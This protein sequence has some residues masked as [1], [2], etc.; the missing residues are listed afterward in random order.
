MSR[1]E[2]FG[3]AGEFE[4]HGRDR[5][6]ARLRP[7]EP[8]AIVGMAC[9]F[10]GA[11]D[12][13]ALWRLLEE[14][15]NAVA[16]KLPGSGSRRVD[17]LFDGAR[18][19]DPACRFC[20]WVDDIDRFDAGFFRI[21][22]VEARLLDPQQRMMLETSWQALEDAGI[23]P[24]RLQGTRTGV[25]T[26]I[27]ND[28]YRMLV[29]DSVR[30]AEAASSLYALS[31]TNLNGTSGRVSFV[32][33]LTG[34]AKAVD[35]ACA[36]SLVSVHD[37][38]A[39]LQ[40]GKADLAIA[41]GVQAILNGRVFELR[42]DSMMLSPDGQC[43]A[44]DASAN[45]YVRGEG[46]GVV[47]LKRLAE[48]EADGDRIWGVIR[49]AAVN[50]GGAS[51]GLTVPNAPALEQVMWTALADAGMSPA[52][53]DY[54]EAH[55]TGT[56][57]GDPIE[58][59][60]VAAVY[61]GAR[62]PDRPLLVGSV[63][64][65]VGHLES[66]AGIAGLIK[67]VLVVERGVIP[68]HLHFRNPNPSLDWEGLPLRVTSSA[69]ELPRRDGRPRVAGVN[70]FGISGTN[71]H[72]VV[73]EY[74]AP[75]RPSY[76]P[77]RVT[78]PKRAVAV[79]LP[80]GSPELPQPEPALRRRDRQLL[81]LSGKSD[82]ALRG[83]AARYVS[84]LDER[85]ETAAAE[86]GALDSLL[87]DMVWTAGT[88]RSHFARRAGLVFADARELR[89]RLTALVEAGP[90]AAAR[91]PAK[92]AFAY[93][94]QGSQWAGMGR[95]LYET[96][97][98]A[99]A[100][101]DRCEAVFRE[102]RGTS[103]LDVM[104]AADGAEELADTAWE[105][106]ALY[107]LGCALTALW[108]SVGVEPA[109]VLGHSVGE[110]AAAQAAGVFGLE[111]GMRFAASRG[112][113]LS[114]TGAGAMAAVFAAPARVEAAVEAANAA[115]SG[116]GVSISAD[117]GGHQ[118]VSGSRADVEAISRRF[119]SEGVRVRRLNTSKAFHSAL[120]EPAL[121]ALEASLRG[122]AVHPPV[123][124]VVS[125]LTGRRV[126]PGQLLDAAYWRRHAREPVAFARGART[127]AELG[128]DLIVEIGPR[129]VLAP[130]AASAWP[131]SASPPAP[132][133][134]SSLR[135][136]SADAG[137]GGDFAGAVAAAYEAGIPIRFEGLFAGEIRRRIS[138]PGYPFQRER[139]W[140]EAPKRRHA[141]EGH[142]LLGARRDSASGETTF[143]TEVFP[144]D[145][146]WLGDHRVFGRVIAPGALYGAMAASVALSGESGPAVVE[147][148]QL[149]S[150]L[151]FP[152]G[153]SGEEA[154]AAGRR[155]QVVVGAPE[156][157]G[158]R[159]ARILSRTPAEDGWTLHTECRIV[160][161]AGA[162]R[163][164]G[165]VDLEDLE[166]TL[167]PVDVPSLYRARSGTGIDLGPSF[168]TLARA[169]SRPG[170]ALGEVRLPEASRRD[171]PEIHP[172]LLDGCFQVVAAARIRGGREDAATY[173]PFG[174]ERLWLAGG[175]PER[176]YCHV[177]M[178]RP[179]PGPEADA[180]GPAEVLTG[181]LRFCDPD[182]VV[183]GGVDGYTVK[184][185][186]P[187]ALFSAVEGVDELLY[188]VVWRERP[189]PPA[190]MSA[191]FLP[192]PATVAEGS[193]PLAGYLAEE[194]VARE[195]R[196][197]L[198][199]DLERWSRS[200][201]LAT[202]NEL[203]WRPATG[204][205]VDPERLRER[206]GVTSDHRRLFRR[207][208]EMLAGSGFLEEAGDGFVVKVGTGDRWPDGIPRDLEALPARMAELY[209]HG[210]TEIGLFGR[211]G[212]ALAEVLRGQADPL[213]LLFS[214]GDPTPA[215][216]Y[217]KAPIARAA[218][219][220]LGEA[221]R[222][223]VAGLPGGRRLRVIEVGAGTG[224]ATAAVLPELPEGR[225]D[226]M[227]TDISAGFF[228]EAEA[229]FGDGGGCIEYRP[230]DIEKDPAGQGFD[231]H[232]YD[233][234]IAS[235]V[236]HAT[237]DLGETLDH[238]RRLLAPSGELVALENLR[239]QGWM[240][241]TFG[242]LDGWWRFADDYRPHHALASPEV[243]RRA[244]ADA[245][246]GEVEVLG[247]DEPG[248]A[249]MPD[250]GV[251][252]AK[253]PVEVAEAPG[254][255]VLIA[256]RGG[257]A[258]ELANGLASRNQTVWL[259]TDGSPQEEARAAGAA[260]VTTV[261]VEF[262]RRESWRT[263]L[264]G[265]AGDP[266][267]EGVVHL[268]ALDG[269]GGQATTRE[270]AEDVR[271][272]GASSLALAQGLAD[273]DLVPARGIWFITRGAQV[274]EREHLGQLAGATL[275]GFGKALT[276]EAPQLQ[277]RMIDL[278]PAPVAPAAGLVD[279]LLSPDAEDHI[280]YR[281]GR[282]QAARLVRAGTGPERLEL[283]EDSAWALAPDPT[284]VF[285]KPRAV[286]VPAR[287]L[288]PREVRVAVEAAGLNF[289]DVFRSLGF[290]EEGNLGREMC[291]RIAAVGA[292]VS[293]VSA[294]DQVVGLGFGAFAREMVTHEELVA[295]APPG[296]A[297]ARLATVPS[298]FVSAAL[299]FEL[300]GL[301]PGDRV[302]IHAGAG[303]VGLAAIQLAQAAGA[304]VFA[305]ASA[306][307]QRYLRSLGVE[308][309]F[310]SRRTNFGE[311]IG[312]ATDGAGVTVVL[313]SLTG[314]GFIDA[315]LSCL[316]EGGRF[317]E[318]AR[319][320][321]LSGEEMAAARPDVAYDILEL[322]VLKKTDPAWVGRVLRG[323][324]ERISAGELEP[325]VH[326]RWPLAEAGAAL[327]FMRS[328]RHLGKIV[329]TAPPL[330]TGRL[331]ADRTYLVTGG[332]GGIGCAVAAWLA[333]H[334]AGAIVLNG[335]RPPGEEAEEAVRRLRER[336][337]TV[338]VEIADVSDPAAVDAML[339]RVDREMP[340]LGGVIH[341][342]GVLSDGA[343]A[344]QSWERFESVLWPKVLGAWHLH[345]AT[346]GRDLD[347]FVLF[348]SRVGVM[349]NPG[350]TNHAAANAFL[351]QLAGHRR[352]L[353]LHGQSIAWG[354]W[355]E[356]GEAAEQR[357]RIEGR[358][359]ALGGRWFTP[360]QGLRA[361]E[362]LVRQDV[363]TSVVMAM[364]WSVFE[365]AVGDRP[366]FLDDLLTSAPDSEPDAGVSADDLL[367]QLG[368]TAA[369]ERQSLM[370]P[371]LQQ[372][373]KAV[374]RLP[375][376]PDPTVG[377][378]DLG[379]DSLMAVELRN[380]LNRALAGMSTVSNT[381]VF[382]YPDIETLARHLADE[383]GEL[384]APT[385]ASAPELPP[386]PARRP[387]PERGDEAIAVVGMACRL[388]GA[389]D[390]SAFWNQLM[391]GTD[392]VTD[393]RPDSGPW[394]GAVGDPSTADGACRRGGFV[395]GL[396]RFDARFFGIRPI[397]ARMMDPRQ[398]MLLETSW[399]A[400]EDAGIDPGP[401]KGS[402]A[403]VFAGLGSSE[404]RDLI[405]ATGRDDSY[406]GTAASVAIGRIAYAL[407]LMGPAVPLDM[408]CASSLV[409]VHQAAA[410]L[411]Q[412]EVDLALAGGVHAIL[413]P[414]VM[415]FMREYGMLSRTG[416]CRT[417]DAAADGFV[418][419]EGCGMV[420]LK[421]LGDAEA[422]GDQVW[423]LVL[424]SAV[425][426]NG[427][428][429]ALTVPNG[430]A[431]EQLFEAA[432]SRAGIAPPDVDYL[433]VHGTGSELGD[434]IEVRAAAAVY[435]RGRDAER[436][437][438]MGTVKTNIG[439]LE[440]A[441][442]VAGL[443][444]VL[445]AMRHRVIPKHLHLESPSPHMDWDDLPVRVTTETTA[446]P[447]ARDRP[448][449]AGVSA[450]GISGTN[451]HL[452]VEGYGTP[453]D[454][455]GGAGGARLAAGPARPVP[456][457]S[458]EANGDLELPE[459]GF[460][461]RRTRLLPLSAK[462]D[463]ALRDLAA[464]YVT[465][466]DEH[467][468]AIKAGSDADESPL[469][470]MAWTAAVGRSHFG[471]R[472]PVVF[473]DAASLKQGLAGLV[474]TGG[475]PVRQPTG[476][477]AFA[478]AAAGG[479]WVGVAEQLYGSEPVFRTVLER[480]DGVLGE[481]RGGSLLEAMSGRA[482]DREDPVW[483]QAAVYAF[484]CGLAALWSSVGVRPGVVCG[485]G[486]GQI[487]AAQAAG[488]VS[489]EA[490][491]VLAARLGDRIGTN[492]ADM[493]SSEPPE[494]LLDG[495]LLAP[496]RLPVVA[497]ATGEVMESG[498]TPDER[499]WCRQVLARPA[500]AGGMASLAEL[501]VAAIVDL[502]PGAPMSQMAAMDWPNAA[503]E[504]RAEGDRAAP[505]VVS[506]GEPQAAERGRTGEDVFV[507]AV[508]GA[509]KAGLPLDFDGLFAGE[510][511]RRISLPA[512]PFERRPFWFDDYEPQS[513][514]PPR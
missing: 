484:E 105:Q 216:L 496:P 274:L 220:L 129:P 226:Y 68:K 145:P 500:F 253:G 489:L 223:L 93:T 75:D 308:H 393:G 364:D 379:M 369:A 254:A 122:V 366:P 189:L 356:I 237:R 242:Q 19:L 419:G 123:L 64:T 464:R 213:T 148:M 422:D 411:R 338:R 281:S 361:F 150:P 371:F 290:I 335:R 137:A 190:L 206:L 374:L 382:D 394:S 465:W 39:D 429:A 316:A 449:V 368:E 179:S 302:L 455:G 184:R 317:V 231:A 151:V 59:N 506:L 82:R 377:F 28:E 362:R 384:A 222:K 95:D 324:I 170:E 333:E 358:R 9:R 3:S 346:A 4:P 417:F 6:G 339:A 272:A 408:T 285:E 498:A 350:Q 174:W 512:Y 47:V 207:M 390:L 15:G 430:V 286:P 124:E 134:L 60:A 466:V 495:G 120:V 54:L 446:W 172:L 52:E 478:Y 37:A 112:T 215:D 27:S 326:S 69:M 250:R 476:R 436:P 345:R 233:L 375:S 451:A 460:R 205:A 131:A 475:V 139:Y 296:I 474:E 164:S 251:I 344:N 264:E 508:A 87:S 106:P 291:G 472:A 255:W 168:R 459:T 48:A 66:A 470:D 461:Q 11:P 225:F 400:L 271:R 86:D 217:L 218:N 514:N 277:P 467:A 186:T 224:S 83:L 30:P 331:R 23:D 21:S 420:V 313:N 22:P 229:R 481:E 513:S 56:A 330:A 310:D 268:A 16:E 410:S 256:D 24:D 81:P 372:E 501:G 165:R 305:T 483:E 198:L 439:H 491:A 433:E 424:G 243:W 315:S 178:N 35:A 133:T 141:G 442:G 418:R 199:T 406:L 405:A 157:D 101:F 370:V 454:D 401:L 191:G 380:R 41:A 438:L 301:E 176:V 5:S 212:A 450:F 322:D 71:A 276:R 486:V 238:C 321:I 407:G 292:D 249:E 265:L 298:A 208:L 92:V 327:A 267:L 288:E 127:L 480:C 18:H 152:E 468:A 25:Y 325:L 352:A 115:S 107:A 257:A 204:E 118:V 426:Q 194:G 158:S 359:A 166:R 76:P 403:G 348:S 169:W 502:A 130:M 376:L 211:C 244:L 487:A 425:N 26:G 453:E 485:S 494:A 404:Y 391:A 159:P 99:R 125:N 252:V 397:E 334:G 295:P 181:E 43:K 88:G 328:A 309:V 318:L 70:S 17:E 504:I 488:M 415:R 58:I 323:V 416:R 293:S 262:E 248:S 42:A 192:D 140:L 432:V 280:A 497:G 65:N 104:F 443:I 147:D 138:I 94:G 284:G 49:G 314:E 452:L 77:D 428:S 155:V 437:L 388:P 162:L 457:R 307:K 203:G 34:P 50:H 12:I 462:S 173:L 53:V 445:L 373:L 259:V 409:A 287:P 365:D 395:E 240:D 297:P 312:R 389:P 503:E 182:G 98:V 261:C 509:Y 399:H 456:V 175:I 263:L 499:S 241:L 367:S 89:G 279:E 235:N 117:N 278:D 135:P 1:D 219:R 33:G 201:A 121:D 304:E 353:G 142:P 44:F 355:S 490:G 260:R 136:P 289:W 435:G 114:R 202:L 200:R 300:S 171:R 282:R 143:E 108:S 79:P 414:A 246:F 156:E 113:L 458:G 80:A 507:R 214:S 153:A 340:P 196:S 102:E 126:R 234:L 10:P 469:A 385:T 31:G 154:E 511:R 111:D 463:R 63:K 387:R 74:R 402:R 311:E 245:R 303:G 103:L 20:A 209:P 447:A 230:L 440:S 84:W 146:E 270:M 275:W 239:G 46:C 510:L 441:A 100:V 32:L 273:S 180:A 116:V 378:F 197:A 421:R 85:E 96:E 329:V 448:P 396:D 283:P 431:Q 51:V 57:V 7:A 29:L 236:L 412:G 427:A 434:P 341:S 62:E 78:G 479:D 258:A 97:P 471:H 477:L 163:S 266:P 160:R 351:D 90:V 149:Q 185:A 167:S 109:V 61:G 221:V 128:V 354:A 398:R 73:E 14:G 232:G 110:I 337:A 492:G 8:V 247:L 132:A 413:S 320:D 306:S 228:A 55:G 227:Y 319:R 210:V 193:A 357:E 381:A 144:S 188:E 336:G 2:R 342:V 505:L 444:K 386:V 13:P 343:L 383:L 473:D 349:G 72:I 360:E 161:G 493:A 91:P 332:L 392:A 36:S 67:A 183:L 45:G 294:G 119:E 269:H 423:G 347:L 38:V 40:Q 187:E 195:D 299:S 482:E 363:T 177:R